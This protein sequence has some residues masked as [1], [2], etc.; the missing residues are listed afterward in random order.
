MRVWMMAAGA[1]ALAG[2]S[3]VAATPPP[4]AP[5]AIEVPAS[6]AGGACRLLDYPMIEEATGM[7]FDVSAATTQRKTYTCV[8][9]TQEASRPDLALSVTATSADASIF[10]DEVVPDGAKQV[11]GLGKAAYRR[12]LASGKGHGAGVEVGWL[13]GDGRL[14]YLRYTFASGQ[15]KAAAEEF[16]PKLV[17]LA[18][19]IDTSSL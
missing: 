13:S 14:M 18:K 11:K 8:V 6:A 19:K 17:T 4:P 5:P 7:R 15:D 2:C 1:L 9:Q 12:T 16:A 3:E 10:A